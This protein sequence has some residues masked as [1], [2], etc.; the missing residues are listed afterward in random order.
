MDELR[1]RLYVFY[2][3]YNP[4]NNHK[5]EEIARTYAGKEVR[6]LYLFCT[7]SAR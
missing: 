7:F 2:E 4:E 1:E 6:F 3:R 5:V